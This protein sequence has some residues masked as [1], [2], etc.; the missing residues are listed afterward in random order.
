MRVSGLLVW[1]GFVAAAAACL[2]AEP[3]GAAVDRL[4]PQLSSA[5]A[6]ARDEA[7]RALLDLGPAIL[8][9]VIAARRGA[10]GET[11]FRLRCIQHRLESL[12]TAELVETAL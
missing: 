2:A 8:P 3:H 5:A 4:V 9:R 6:T 7:E 11:E 12:A 10:A 1:G